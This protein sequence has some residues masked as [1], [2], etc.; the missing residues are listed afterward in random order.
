MMRLN[1]ATLAMALALP[2]TAMAQTVIDPEAHF[3][4]GPFVRDGRLAYVEYAGNVANTWDGTK[5]AQ[6]WSEEGCGP[7]AIAP[8]GLGW[9]VTCY[10]AGTVVM[11][12]RAGETAATFA[13]DS[14]GAAMLGPNDIAPDG[15]G[16]IWFTASGPWESA[17][18]VGKVYHFTPGE[19]APRPVAEDLHYANGLSLSPA[20]G[21]LYV[22]ESE[23]GRIISFATEADGGLHDRRLFARLFLLDEAS[24]ASAYPDGIEWGPDGNL[25]VGQYSS[26]RIL[27]ITPDAKLAR[28]LEVPATTAPNLAFSADGKTIYVMTVDQT[29]ATPYAG[30]VLAMPLD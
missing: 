23:A 10:D 4:E 22:A 7:S 30:R 6:L 15:R 21:R 1:A 17:P 8:F 13:R 20:D 12:T 18:I 3:P 19:I 2:V 27:A 25:W 14:R 9:I 11:V 28:V 24:G 29:D 16:G 26:G 5:L